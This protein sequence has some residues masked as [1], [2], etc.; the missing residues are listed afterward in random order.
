[1]KKFGFLILLMVTLGVSA[2]GF[3]RWAVEGD[4]G[5]HSIGDESATL[6]DNYNHFGGTLRYNIN[7]KFGLGLSYGKDNL[8]MLNFDGGI[9]STNYNRYDLEAFVDIFDV[10]DL[11]NNFITILGHGGG[12]ISTIDAIE[13]D[14]Y[15]SVFNMRGGLTALFKMSRTVALKVDASTT[16]NISQDRTLDGYQDISNAG[17]NSTVDNLSAGLVFYLGK[18]GKDGK[19]RQHA[20]WVKPTVPQPITETIYLKSDP[21]V[22]NIT[23]VVN[24]CAC[25]ARENIFF[26]HDK[27]IVKETEGTKNALVKIYTYLKENPDSKVLI[28]TFASATK[29][30]DEYNYELSIKRANATEVKLISMGISKSRI[31]KKGNGKD[32]NWGAESEHP[33]ARRAELIIK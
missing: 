32:F 19:K 31:E 30:T 11:Q 3:N 22:N 5:M 26:D 2:Q 24:V 8:S 33:E 27:A 18:K 4:F 14:Y 1:M 17:I 23:K 12:G 13:T 16:V 20:D 21:I 6:R 15:Q 7:P 28:N 25:A 10:L 9:A 29:S